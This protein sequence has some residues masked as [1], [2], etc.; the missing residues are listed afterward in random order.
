MPNNDLPPDEPTAP[1]QASPKV[2]PAPPGVAKKVRVTHLT[3]MKHSRRPITVVTAY[4]ATMA[5]LCDHGSVDVILVGDSLGQVV[6][7]L[8]TTLPVTMDM[9]VLHT[10][11]VARGAK[12]SLIVADMPF[13]SFQITPEQTLENAG[14]LMKHGAEAVKLETGN[15]RLIET[16]RYI[17]EAGIPVMAHLGLTPQSVHALGGYR[18]QGRGDEEAERLLRLAHLVE[19]AGAFAVVLELMPSE[20]AARITAALRIPTIGIGAGSQCD[21][22]VLVLNDLLGLTEHPPRFARKY[23]DL[24]AGVL[25]S[26]RKYT[27]D[28]REKHF[29]AD[30]HEFH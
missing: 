8:D 14:R 16:L 30:E 23:L 12:R 18:V 10:E 20:L 2:P 17:V 7:G 24:R 15:E 1:P 19:A 27:R 22:Q 13:M 21:G 25:R 9:M 26:I 5:A 3:Q 4:D 29:P 28:V 6:H 11:A